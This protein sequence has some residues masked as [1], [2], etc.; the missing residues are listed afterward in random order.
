MEQA[1]SIFRVNWRVLRTERNGH[2]CDFRR[3]HLATLHPAASKVRPKPR[4]RMRAQP[5]REDG[6]TINLQE[7]EVKAGHVKEETISL[8]KL[9]K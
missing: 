3:H 8:V 5:T 9:M 2:Q 7:R 6:S 4:Q 1:C